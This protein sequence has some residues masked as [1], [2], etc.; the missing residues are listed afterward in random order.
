[1]S[2][3]QREKKGE[4]AASANGKDKT[5]QFG[6][7]E[8]HKKIQ[9]NKSR[10]SRV[11]S[12]YESMD[13]ITLTELRSIGTSQKGDEKRLSPG[14]VE[15]RAGS[16]KVSFMVPCYEKKGDKSRSYQGK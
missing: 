2:Q 8:Q 16:G 5:A 12:G 1:M 7:E 9:R 6:L 15:E 3:S 13:F 11:S 4:L 10:H 14:T